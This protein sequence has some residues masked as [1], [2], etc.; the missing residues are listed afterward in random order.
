MVDYSTALQVTGAG[1]G[2]R[3]TISS[4]QH[5]RWLMQTQER[6]AVD[7]GLYI[8]CSRVGGDPRCITTSIRKHKHRPR[9]RTVKYTVALALLDKAL[10]LHHLHSHPITP[11]APFTP[12][13]VS[14]SWLGPKGCAVRCGLPQM[15]RDY[16]APEHLGRGLQLYKLLLQRAPQLDSVQ[17]GLHHRYFPVYIIEVREMGAGAKGGSRVRKVTAGSGSTM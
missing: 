17:L 3:Q 4:Q 7:L 16:L 9:E 11:P 13:C 2:T 6:G 5:V 10:A 14:I 1:Q 15:L 12:S 8:F